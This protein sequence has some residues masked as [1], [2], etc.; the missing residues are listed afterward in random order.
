MSLL[1]RYRGSLLGLA[2]GDALG[3]PVEGNAP[4][5]FR[6]VEEL[7]NEGIWTDDTS[8]A[9][10]LAESLIICRG[11]NALDQMERY[12]RWF[13][14]GHLSC[15]EP[16]YGIGRT[17]RRALEI[18][19]LTGEV[20]CGSEDPQTAGNGCLMRLAPLP[21]AYARRPREAIEQA[22]D[23]TRTTHRAR[24]CVD[25]CR[26]FAG[27]MVGAI[28]GVSKETLLSDHYAPVSG[29]WQD[30]PLAPSIAK[31][32]SGSFKRKQ[33]PGIRGTGYVVETLEA[34]LWAFFRSDSFAEGV[35]LA[36]N[37]GDDTDTTAAVYGQ[38]AGAFYGEQA[39]PEHWRTQV[40]Q[41]ELIASFAEQLYTLAEELGQAYSSDLREWEH[42][43][44][45][46]TA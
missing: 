23:S 31:I 15:V 44:A 46:D 17:V 40:L 37:L 10:C 21:L 7:E 24:A 30:T 3:E 41:H 12:L 38:L 28:Q 14:E 25:A 42:G 16:G 20:Y 9:L 27:L 13:R 2:V 19:E 22:G 26:Y 34:A 4:G 1:E 39:I 33:P 11:N 6:L 45:Q 36:V 5:T 18:F 8:M 32:A 35:L 43:T 29:V